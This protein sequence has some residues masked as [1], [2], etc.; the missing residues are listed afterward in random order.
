[1]L[2]PYKIKYPPIPSAGKYLFTTHADIEY[3]VLFAKQEQDPFK[4]TL[5]FGV[6]NEM[7]EGEEY[8]LTN[9]GE[10][11]R[12]MSTIVIIIKDFIIHHP[13]THTLVFSAEPTSRE[14]DKTA[15]KRL[16]L[17]KKYIP[18]IFDNSWK[19]EIN[20][21]KAKI[22]KKSPRGFLGLRDWFS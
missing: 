2:E 13:N 1:M 18:E 9:K 20:G 11:Y 6:L 10:A 17:Y 14:D 5:A 8:S 16:N 19:L 15:T 4:V 21:N 22:I 7:Y 12:V 3:E